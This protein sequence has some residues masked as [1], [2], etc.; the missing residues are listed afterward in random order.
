MSVCRRKPDD[1]AAAEDLGPNTSYILMTSP[2]GVSASA[3]P[4]KAMSGWTQKPFT[5]SKSILR[6]FRVT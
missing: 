1:T 5:A 4:F 2:P 3:S 6:L